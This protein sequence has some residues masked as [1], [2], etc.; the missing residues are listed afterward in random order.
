ML[1]LK[2]FTYVL[3]RYFTEFLPILI[4]FCVDRHTE[5][6]I[7]K[8]ILQ[9]QGLNS[10]IISNKAIKYNSAHFILLII[11]IYVASFREHKQR[12]EATDVY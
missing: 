12:L 2:S 9:L 8:A 3:S 6:Q 10:G 4:T 11:L 1:C 5:A 7:L